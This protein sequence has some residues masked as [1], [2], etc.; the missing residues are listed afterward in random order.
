MA[1]ALVKSVAALSLNWKVD[2][3]FVIKALNTIA[4][5]TN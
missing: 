2:V 1:E 3:G 4:K 5:A